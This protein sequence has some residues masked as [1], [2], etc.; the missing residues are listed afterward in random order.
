MSIWQGSGGSLIVPE[1]LHSAGI[2]DIA[3]PNFT[4][5]GDGTATIA[6]ALA[7][8]YNNPYFDGLVSEYLIPQATLGFV[9]GGQQFVCVKYNSGYP[10]YYVEN[11][12][13]AINDSDIILVFV[14]WRQDNILHSADQDSIALGLPN[15]INARLIDTDPY[16]ITTSTSLIPAEIAVPANRTITITEAEVYRGTARGT[17]GAFNSS[18]DLFTKAISTAGGWVYTNE[19]TYNNDRYNPASGGEL[20]SLPAKWLYRLYY[21]SIGDVKQTFY[22]E[23]PDY[24][25]TEA[26]ARIASEVGRSD[27]PL[28]LTGHCLLVGRSII[29]KSS[30][31]GT[32]EPFV[33]SGGS[34]ISAGGIPEA[35]IDGTQYGRQNASWTPIT[36]GGGASVRVTS[37]PVTLLSEDTSTSVTVVDTAVTAKSTFS[38]SFKD[39]DTLVQMCTATVVSST[40]TVG[41]D[42]LVVAPDGATGTYN[43]EVKIQEA[44]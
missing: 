26:A 10:I 6:Q 33:R 25:S 37:V 28:L 43:I 8:L 20:V 41:Y 9:D 39:E 21:R 3:V 44:V 36:G 18:T 5:N 19:T 15:K 38:A 32:T 4:D 2:S 42:I 7:C 27:L 30:A 23:S 24:Y 34:F 17:V 31:T 40:P 14:V 11:N 35:P 29:L 22:V 1:N 12:S 13:L 16:A